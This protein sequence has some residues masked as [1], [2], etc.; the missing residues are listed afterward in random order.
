[1]TAETLI[2]DS[3]ARSRGGVLL[4]FRTVFRKELTEWL[5]GRAGFI[6]SAVAIA[7][8][9]FTTLIPF[10]VKAT[11]QAAV[12]VTITN[13]PTANVLVGW[14]GSQT[15]AVIVVL[16]TMSL[17]S[18]E[19]DRGTLAWSLSNPVSPSSFIAAKFCAAVLVVG[20]ATV[21]IPLTIS[22]LV[23]TVAYGSI[24]NLG[25]VAL[26]AGLF[27]TLPIFYIALTIA[28]GTVVKSTAGVAGIAF[29]VIFLPSIFGALLPIVN[30]A[31]PTS[32]GMW[33]WGTAT[34]EAAS[35]LTLAGWAV[36]VAILM[37]GAKLVFDRQEF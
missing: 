21:I 12:G 9:I 3:T 32:I 7:S 34:G 26:F 28:L 29:L 31:S 15:F 22:V 23:A 14:R 16:A 18:A 19:R 4:G 17:L 8:A 2:I 24:P 20:T 27:L 37:A 10:V 13:D 35:M 11:G 1:M 33:A 5:R 25:T 6:V 30:E 36:S